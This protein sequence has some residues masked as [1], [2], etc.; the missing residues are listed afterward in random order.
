[1]SRFVSAKLGLNHSVLYLDESGQCFRFSGGS[2]AWRTHNPGNLVPGSISKKH[3]AIGSTG[4]F[5][6]F[7]D[8]DVGH[9]ALIDLLQTIYWNLSINALVEKYAPPK[10]NDVKKYKKFL[11][12]KTG[13]LDDR[14]IKAFTAD[15]FKNLWIAIEQIEGY[16]EGIITQID[17]VVQVR[18]K[19]G[20]IYAYC[21][22]QKGWISKET[23]VQLVQNGM[24]DLVLCLSRLGKQYLRSKPDDSA[25]DNLTH[26][27]EGAH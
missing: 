2:W 4:K 26:L 14:M 18:K 9:L 1:M 12:D 22:Q 3:G 8:Y 23:C 11:R 27:V 19:Q 6:I 5:A 21:L 20:S 16:R 15:E 7:S 24:V 25:D 10:E 13:I 17:Q